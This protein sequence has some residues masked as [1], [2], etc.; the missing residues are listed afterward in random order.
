MAA[1]GKGKRGGARVIYLHLETA[2]V[3]YLVYV[4]DK[5]EADDLTAAQKKELKAIAEAIK[6][7]YKK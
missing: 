6:E 5:G 3:I 7:E 2:T 4:Y 1:R